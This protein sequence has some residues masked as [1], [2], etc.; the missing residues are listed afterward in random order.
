MYS[1]W[2]QQWLPDLDCLQI[3]APSA[4]PRPTS[5]ASSSIRNVQEEKVSLLKSLDMLRI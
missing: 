5:K 4:E 2:M 1:L 3:S